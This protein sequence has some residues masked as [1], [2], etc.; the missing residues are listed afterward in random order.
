MHA[1]RSFGLLLRM[2]RD[3]LPSILDLPQ[4]RD[5]RFAQFVDMAGCC[6]LLGGAR[7]SI[8]PSPF[9]IPFL[10]LLPALFRNVA[11]FVDETPIPAAN[12]QPTYRPTHEFAGGNF[13]FLPSVSTTNEVVMV[14][15]S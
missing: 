9:T 2:S 12:A 11:R 14:K 13:P 4:F 6:S 8:H 10:S 5:D 15:S 3:A 7:P 1:E